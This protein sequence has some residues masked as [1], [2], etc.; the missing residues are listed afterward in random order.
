MRTSTT[1][2]AASRGSERGI[3]PAQGPRGAAPIRHLLSL[4]RN[5]SILAAGEAF[6]RGLTFIAFARLA[7]VLDPGAFG[8]VEA[9]L[10]I[11]M[12]AGLA[13]DLGLGKLGAR[14]VAR[15][16]TVVTSLAGRV[17]SVRL[18][19]A[20]GVCALLVL[21]AWLVPINPVLA[22]LLWGLAPS[23]F[24]LPFVLNWVFQGLGRMEW[25]AV[26]PVVRQG[27]FLVVLLLLV[28]GPFD[29]NLLPVAEVAA[30]AVMALVYLVVFRT[31][32]G[33]LRIRP[34]SLWD[35]ELLA[36]ALPIGGSS[37]VWALRTFLP[38]L[39]VGGLLG[40]VAAGLF[41]VG[42]RIMMVYHAALEVYFTNLLPALS[43]EADRPAELSRLVRRALTVIVPP[44]IA[45]GIASFWIAPWILGVVFGADYV[46]PDSVRSF[47]V[48]TWLVPVLAFRGTAHFALI[49][50]HRQRD[51]L[52]CSLGGLAA[53]LVAIAP[54]ATWLGVPGAAVAMLVS[55]LG[56][57]V[58]TWVALRRGLRERQA[59]LS[60][61]SSAAGDGTGP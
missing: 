20:C 54:L 30:A 57:T 21:G 52:V 2:G 4:T 17:A 3:D 25:Y 51:D 38:V 34:R 44:T 7:R 6:A 41:A 50:I 14:E 43:R 35:R 42:H 48:L 24:G 33:P 39:V 60:E 19:L 11:M 59:T 16:P 56:A 12:F 49:A 45:L 27:T 47:L 61:G 53:L 26:P 58:A 8:L 29:V 1:L 32:V 18:A 15:D 22:I 46:Q 28:R 5:L 23:L 13:V 31:G 55:Q 37:F 40:P 9:A 36:D 10:A